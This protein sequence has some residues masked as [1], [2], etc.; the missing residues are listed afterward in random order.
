MKAL[1]SNSATEADR[2]TWGPI[3]LVTLVFTSPSALTIYLCSRP[4][5]TRNTYNNQVYDPLILRWS[6]I[7]CGRIDPIRY[8]NEIGD[9]TLD[10]MNGDPVGGYNQFSDVINAFDWA[11]ATVT[12][13]WAYANAL[14]I[15]DPIAIFKGKIENIEKLSAEFVGVRISDI[16]LEYFSKW[17]YE[18][19]DTATYAGA[20]PDDVGKMLPQ[21]W[22]SCK[23]VP[24][25]AV[26][27]GGLTTLAEDLAAAAGTIQ[28]TD[29]SKFGATGDIWIDAEKI[30]YGGKTATSF[31]GCTRAQGGTVDVS[32]D[33]GAYIQEHQTNYI[34][35]ISHAI[36]AF[37]AVYIAGVL[38][39]AAN[40]TAYTGQAGDQFAPYGS[41]ATI[42][43]TVRPIMEKQIDI[44]ANDTITV[45][46]ATG[47]TDGIGVSDTIDVLD[48]IGVT[49]DISFESAGTV[50][51][52]YPVSHATAG[53]TANPT[54]AYDGSEVTFATAGGGGLAGSIRYTWPATVY[55]VITDIK[56]WALLRNADGN[57]VISV[58]SNAGAVNP[59]TVQPPSAT[60]NWFRFDI[61]DTGWAV[62]IRFNAD[63]IGLEQIIIYELYAEF[64][65][66]PTLS[67]TGSASKTGDATKTG[68]AT[69]TGD[70][71]L[72]GGAA[73]KAG[74]VTITGNSVADTVVGGRVSADID[75][76][77]DD[78]SG[79]YTGVADALI[80]RPDHIFKHWLIGILG[81]TTAD[82]DAIYYAAAG[83]LY[84]SNSYTLG[85]CLLTPPDVKN[86]FSTAAR[87][88]Q[89]IQFWE[90]GIHHIKFLEAAPSTDQAIS[91]H[92]ITLNLVSIE[93]TMRASIRNTLEG[94][95][96]RHW[97]TF[98]KDAYRSI[99]N[100]TGAASVTKYGN[101]RQEEIFDFIT[102]GTM[103]QAIL[104]WILLDLDEPRLLITIEIDP[105]LIK[106]EM[107]DVITFDTA[108]TE[109][110][111][112]LLGLV[113]STDQFWV[114]AKSYTESLWPQIQVVE[115]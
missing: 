69:K 60:I 44:A 42:K 43:F 3:I 52:D 85:I 9:L 76:Y 91:G 82:I 93:Y 105:S 48:N 49:D 113:D 83:V 47:V 114:I 7:T 6:E 75:G 100:A 63:A 115:V 35:I 65:Y 74:T 55:G 108:E 86:L 45:S 95:Y 101:A 92:R 23:R 58:D 33:L 21:V 4:F 64:T 1:S 13:T 12:I 5:G 50:R 18:I 53:Q 102:D 37:N 67:K 96:D 77:K 73:T 15:G 57:D 30:A 31:T 27:A 103:A 14:T 97:W 20:D 16:A 56:I 26:D 80:E 39:P 8:M 29:T 79:T 88:C 40:Y 2:A 104:D 38:Q 32:H 28:A 110:N 61:D 41:H 24:F 46:G 11:F 71:T 98:G 107:G 81:L 90:A 51:K 19:I 94:L 66:T 70:A 34:Y 25:M 111:N 106:L 54:N 36:K 68:A 99:V 59:A 89:S 10:I 17:P 62:D 22:G 109:L 78:G 84:N 112:I 72:T 87:Q